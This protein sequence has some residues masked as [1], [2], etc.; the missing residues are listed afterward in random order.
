MRTKYIS[1]DGIEFDTEVA[2]REYE[3]EKSISDYES[4]WG[5]KIPLKKRIAKIREKWENR[6]RNRA[7]PDD[8][9]RSHYQTTRTDSP[10]GIAGEFDYG[11]IYMRDDAVDILFE[12][13]KLLER[14]NNDG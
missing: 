1:Y 5:D 11:I 6:C 12:Y 7:L 13:I 14:E 9:L 2:C 8:Y 3:N 4:M 10:E